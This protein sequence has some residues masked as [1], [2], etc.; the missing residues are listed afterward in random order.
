[1]NELSDPWTNWVSFKKAFPANANMT[2]ATK[3]L[4]SLAVPDAARGTSGLAG[5]LEQILRAAHCRYVG[6]RECKKG[7]DAPPDARPNGFGHRVLEGK[8]AGGVARLLK[9]VFCQ[10]ELNYVSA[11][12][13]LPEEVFFDPTATAPASVPKVSTGGDLRFPFQFPVRS[14]VDKDIELFLMGNRILAPSIVSA[15]RV[16]DDENDIFSQERCALLADITKTPLPA[17]G[18]RVNARV[19]EAIVAKLSGP[20]AFSFVN[21]SPPQPARIQYLK[22]LLDLV[23]GREAQD[24]ARFDYSE[25]VLG[26]FAKKKAA[27]AS[28]GLAKQAI[29]AREADRKDLARRMFDG[30]GPIPVLDPPR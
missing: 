30:G 6:G 10:T 8:E 25:E 5:D 9:S 7:P 4:V 11:G 17:E 29:V 21:A 14:E 19:R 13:S 22:T 3:E 26:R 12:Q 28:G 16:V 1:M 23:P 15:I 24:A 20:N 27:F 2:G 18:F